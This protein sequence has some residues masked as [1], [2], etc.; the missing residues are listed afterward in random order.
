MISRLRSVVV[1]LF[2][3]FT[4]LT[5]GAAPAGDVAAKTPAAAVSAFTADEAIDLVTGTDGV[6]RFD[7]A[8]DH[9]RFVWDGNPPLTDG[10]PEYHTAFITQGYLYPAGT[11]T[12]TNGVLPNGAPEFPDKVLGQWTC[13]GWWI[14]GGEAGMTA[15]WV[16][17]HLF[18]F[19]GEWGEATVVTTGY[20]L[21]DLVVSLDRAVTGGSGPFAAAGGVQSEVNLG[22]NASNGIN[23]QYEIHLTKS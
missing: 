12:D 7:V 17:T 18:N 15:P 19:G 1:P 22:F 9:S 14:G 2:A 21:D 6:L 5:L 8:E 3:L 23:A 13:T 11:L 4:V 16:S 20:D 10:L